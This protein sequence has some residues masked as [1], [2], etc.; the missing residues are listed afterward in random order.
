VFVAEVLMVA[1]APFITWNSPTVCD[2]MSVIVGE[3]VV[4]PL[5]TMMSFAAG[6][7]RGG[8]QFVGIVQL[9]LVICVQV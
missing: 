3:G 2:G 6:T 8:L 9:E 1:S 5:I 4:E 7:A